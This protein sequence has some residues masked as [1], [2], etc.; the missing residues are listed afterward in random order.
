MEY[1]ITLSDCE[2]RA[3]HGCYDM[4][5]RVGN[6]FSVDL[7]IRASL[8][9][10]AE[11]DDVTR[12]VNYLKAYEVLAAQ[13]KITQ[14]TL[15]RVAENIITALYDAFPEIRHISCTVAKIAPPLGGKIGRVAVTIQR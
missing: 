9:D 14:C 2:F 15:E 11:R 8:G 5:Q 1:T 7:C 13:M 12:T 6:H 4:E 10:A 3:F